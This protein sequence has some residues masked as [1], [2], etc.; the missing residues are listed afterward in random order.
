MPFHCCI[1]NYTLL[2][3]S[4]VL[5]ITLLP[6]WPPDSTGRR[7]R[8]SRCIWGSLGRHTA[9]WSR[10]SSAAD[11]LAVLGAQSQ[12]LWFLSR[13]SHSRRWRAGSTKQF[14]TWTAIIFCFS[15]PPARFSQEP[16][17]LYIKTA[18]VLLTCVRVKQFYSCFEEDC[19]VR[20]TKRHIICSSE[21]HSNSLFKA[22][23]PARLH[24]PQKTHVKNSLLFWVMSCTS[25]LRSLCTT[26]TSCMWLTADTSLRMMRLASVSLKCCFLRILSSN[27]PPPSSSRTR[28]VWSYSK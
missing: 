21:K 27:S 22:Y 28:N 3:R 9:G 17:K 15:P 6:G 23:D 14:E 7:T 24:L 20:V 13:S 11:C 4:P 1:L 12:S 16:A 18:Q 10:E 2:F 19:R 8:H 5:F 25:G 26:P